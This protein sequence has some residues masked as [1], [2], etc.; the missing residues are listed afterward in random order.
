MGWGEGKEKGNAEVG[1]VRAIATHSRHPTNFSFFPDMASVRDGLRK[2]GSRR[3]NI[4]VWFVTN[5]K[6]DVPYMKGE[7]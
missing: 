6:G 1:M 7:R 5:S 2:R 4:R 3:R